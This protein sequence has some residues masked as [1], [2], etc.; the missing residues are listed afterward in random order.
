MTG[1]GLALLV[2]LAVVGLV[3]GLL[4]RRAAARRAALDEA[5]GTL[6]TARHG[7][8]ESHPDGSRVAAFV[9]QDLAA[10]VAFED[11]PDGPRTRLR[12]AFTEDL[13]VPGRLAVDRVRPTRV[14]G[15]AERRPPLKTA[16]GDFD[17]RF[18]IDG[19][20]AAAGLVWRWLDEAGR[21]L[22]RELAARQD[23]ES[24]EPVLVAD[25][26]ARTLE[27]WLPGRVVDEAELDPVLEAL[28]RLVRRLTG[29]PAWEGN[30]P[31]LEV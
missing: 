28:A 16:D 15:L 6:A 27:A 12:L 7:R 5:A 9:W 29:R 2:G 4:A 3:V 10:R 21:A 22:V 8:T 24:E 18:R 25:P 23:R 1:P 26:G 31:G 19:D 11:G 14:G 20:P 13:G 30:A 17:A